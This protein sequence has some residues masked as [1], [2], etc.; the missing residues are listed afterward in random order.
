[1]KTFNVIVVGAGF[2]GKNW[3]K[4][5]IASPRLNLAGVVD[6]SESIL[7]QVAEENS[8]D[9]AMMVTDLDQALE[10]IPADIVVVV[11]PPPCHREH[12]QTAM[13]HGKHVI[14]EKPLADNWEAAQQIAKITADHPN[15]KFMVSQTRRFTRPIQTIHRIIA[16][17]Q[18]GRVDTLCFDHRVNYTGGGYRQK[19]A[20]P[21]IE[22]MI[23][24][25]LDMLRYITGQDAVSVYVEAWNPPWSEFTGK[26]SNNILVTMTNDVHVNYFGT[27]TGRGCLNTYNGVMKI[28]GSEGSLEL[29]DDNTLLLYRNIETDEGPNPAPET[30]PMVQVQHEY[31]NGVIDAFLHAIDTDT[32][33]PCNIEDN[34]KTFAFNCAVL[35]SCKEERKIELTKGM[36]HVR[37]LP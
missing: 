2:W 31:I 20:F 14:C 6:Q 34:L 30:I 35:Q 32:Q 7:A 19:L 23:S 9:Q 26:A 5:A 29:M 13:R 37:N 1:M 33:P 15:Q 3:I 36:F 17:G 11:S 16:S 10:K 8:I 21:I 12:I 24:H 4:T 27:W 22:D 28:M 18:I 25:H